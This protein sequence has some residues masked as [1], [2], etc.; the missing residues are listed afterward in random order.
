MNSFGI[1]RRHYGLQVVAHE[2][3]LMLIVFV[4]GVTG[5]FSGW[6]CKDQP[7]AP[8]VHMME[9]QHVLKKSAIGFRIFAVD[10][11]MGAIDHNYLQKRSDFD[12]F[13]R[14]DQ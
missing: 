14:K 1:K 4:A 10:D 2:V 8:C 3:K 12:S 5:N 11:Y 13:R 6:K 7:P 9:T